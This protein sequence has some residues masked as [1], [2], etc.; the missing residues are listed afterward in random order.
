M[1]ESSFYQRCLD[2]C[3]AS[4]EAAA[5]HPFVRGLAAGTLTPAQIRC[6]L[7][8]DG[9][10]L[11]GYVATCRALADRAESEADRS[12]FEESARLSEEA[13]LDMQARL[14]QALGISSLEDEPLPATTAYSTHEKRCVEDHSR[15][16]AL[17][18]A[19]PCNVLYA[20]VGIRLAGLPE[21]ARPDHPFRGWLDLYADP[22]VQEL[23]ARW[24]AVLD[25]WAGEADAAEQKPALDAFAV[26][27]QCEVDFW[28]QAWQTGSGKRT[29]S[30]G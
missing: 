23:A 4:W 10:Y 22:A 17:A 26:S 1:S 21:A 30:T 6:Y 27:M 29:G 3:G 28:E 14:A 5:T 18:G 9:I 7:I 15:L 24:V 2:G 19:A 11:K 25:R 8:Q 16:V 20:E 13:E 12:L